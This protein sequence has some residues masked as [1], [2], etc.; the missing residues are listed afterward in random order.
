MAR[1]LIL[2]D[3]KYLLTT[4]K[5]L[6]GS[7]HE[8]LATESPF[9]ALQVLEANPD[10]FDLVLLDYLMPGFTGL[11]VLQHLR[12]H[13]VRVPIVLVTGQMQDVRHTQLFDAVLE[14]P[15]TGAQLVGLLG[16]FIELA[17]PPP[18]PAPAI[19]A[20]SHPALRH[21]L[22]DLERFLVEEVHS[23]SATLDPRTAATEIRDRSK[24][25]LWFA[26]YQ[27]R[28]VLGDRGA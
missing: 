6:L 20:D 7:H 19:T 26:W 10:W 21:G 17:P 4:Y 2:D 18:A 22:A 27:L 23:S 14:K 16:R 8:V 24:L 11:E 1:I 15:V 12:A 9:E 5:E 28:S 13:A 25:R 3:N